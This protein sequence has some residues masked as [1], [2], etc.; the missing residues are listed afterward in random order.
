MIQKGKV[1][2]VSG[3]AQGIGKAIV[4]G[5]LKK[6]M[7]VVIA[8][9]DEEAGE[10]T[11]REMEELG[12]VRFIGT[13]VADEQMVREAVGKTIDCFGR[14]DLVVNNAGIMIRK[15]ISELSLDEW[16]RVISVN[17]TGAFL[18]A[19]HSAPFLRERNGSIVN[20]AST[21]ALMSEPDTEAYSAS[22]GGLIALTHALAVSL[23]P[24]VR[25][26]CISPGWIDVN[27]WKKKAAS[28]ELELSRDDHQ[29]HPAG[30][31]GRPEDIAAMVAFLISSDASFITG[32]HFVVDGGMTRKMIYV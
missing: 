23:G 13:D 8:E 27:R 31:V 32:A 4:E 29:Q 22:K 26:N 21:R 17:L 1:A 10:E 9:I 2:I 18:L 25:A 7:R 24:D 28:H 6:A 3:G 5:L 12:E 19:K 11:R 15:S 30:R 20:I 14:L 16:N